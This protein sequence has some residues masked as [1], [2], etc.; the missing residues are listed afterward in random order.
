MQVTIEVETIAG[1]HFMAP[2]TAVR[3]KHAPSCSQDINQLEPDRPI[4]TGGP[5]IVHRVG[6]V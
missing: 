6:L 3:R 1:S 4:D 5:I 2:C